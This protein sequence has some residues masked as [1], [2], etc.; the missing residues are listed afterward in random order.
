MKQLPDWLRRALGLPERFRK[1]HSKQVPME[2]E[3]TFNDILERM[4]SG[5]GRNLQSVGNLK[6]PTLVKTAQQVL[7][8]WK[9]CCEQLCKARLKNI[10]R[11]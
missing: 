6:M 7:E 1:G 8:T 5:H 2:V 10:Y 9:S 3:M 4:L 11:S